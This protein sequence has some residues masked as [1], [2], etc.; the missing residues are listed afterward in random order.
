VPAIEIGSDGFVA[1]LRNNVFFNHPTSFASG[2][3]TIRPGFSEK[4]GETGPA[5]MGYAD[6]N[7]FYNPD[8]KVIR[9]YGLSVTGKAERRDAGFGKYDIPVDGARNAQ[10]HPKFKGPLPAAFPFSDD[11]IRA[12]RISVSK[13]LARYRD[14]Y[15]PGDGS[16]LTDG[17]DP[18]D[19]KG[20][21]IGAI[22]TGK[23]APN[24][25][26][27]RSQEH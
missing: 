11:D 13:I 10:V 12:R 14:A 1:S 22:G 20:S 15:A 2:S 6:Y 17:G 7:L 18:A 26:F 5:R 27:G 19:G 24:D 3:A 21:F 25:R 16:P 9:N 4:L 23:D 8:A